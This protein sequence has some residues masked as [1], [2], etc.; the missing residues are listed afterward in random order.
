MQNKRMNGN[1]NKNK[2]FFKFSTNRFDKKYFY[3]MMVIF[4]Y[5]KYNNTFLLI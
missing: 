3:F 2:A 4:Y 1:T 5:R